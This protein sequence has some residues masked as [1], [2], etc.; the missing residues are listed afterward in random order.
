[1]IR[2]RGRLGNWPIELDIEMEAADWAA[3]GQALPEQEAVVKKAGSAVNPPNDS[4]WQ[5]AQSLLQQAGEISGPQLLAELA[6]LAGS[7][8][9]AKRLLVRLRHAPQVQIE[10]G[11]DAPLYRW[12]SQV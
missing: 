4:L 8:A 9:T 3:L 1:M 12:V 11:V 7:A 2:V 6:A 10:S 5:T